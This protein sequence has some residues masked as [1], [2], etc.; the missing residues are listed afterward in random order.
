MTLT[1]CVACIRE[2]CSCGKASLLRRLKRAMFNRKNKRVIRSAVGFLGRQT[3][4]LFTLASDLR[5]ILME[6]S[7]PTVRAIKMGFALIS[8]VRDALASLREYRRRWMRRRK[9]GRRL[10]I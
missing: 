1:G 8:I 7:L 4:Q 9:H 10:P 3:P 6:H 5:T 2:P